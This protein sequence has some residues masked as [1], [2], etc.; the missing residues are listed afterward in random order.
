MSEIVCVHRWGAEVL[1]NTPDEES[2]DGASLR[3]VQ[4]CKT[5]KEWWMQGSPEPRTLIGRIE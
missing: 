5:C 1:V 4:Q 2:G 3:T